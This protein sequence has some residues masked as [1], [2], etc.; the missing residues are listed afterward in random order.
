MFDSAMANFGAPNFD[1]LFNLN[2]QF[3]LISADGRYILTL[4]NTE[5]LNRPEP[6]YHIVIDANGLTVM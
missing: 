3:R 5:V 6:R 1:G 4:D 2:I